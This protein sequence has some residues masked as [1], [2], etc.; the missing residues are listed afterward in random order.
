MPRAPRR[1][2]GDFPAVARRVAPAAH[3]SRSTQPA[4]SLE[5]ARDELVRALLDLVAGCR[6]PVL[7]GTNELAMICAGPYT[8]VER[9][10]KAE[11]LLDR[12]AIG[13]PRAV[14]AA[15]NA[16]LDRLAGIVVQHTR[17]PDVRLRGRAE[18]RQELTTRHGTA[19]LR[20]L[21]TAEY[22]AEYAQERRGSAALRGMA[23]GALTGA[24]FQAVTAKVLIK[25]VDW[26]AQALAGAVS[27]GAMAAEAEQL[28]AIEDVDR[29]RAGLK[30]FYEPLHRELLP[31]ARS[32]WELIDANGSSRAALLRRV[33]SALDD[34]DGREGGWIMRELI[35]CF[36][37]AGVTVQP[38]GS[39]SDFF[40]SASAG[41]VRVALILNQIVLLIATFVGYFWL[42]NVDLAGKA[43]VSLGLF[44][45]PAFTWF[46][47]LMHWHAWAERWNDSVAHR[48]EALEMLTSLCAEASELRGGVS[49]KGTLPAVRALTPAPAG[50]GLMFSLAFWGVVPSIALVLV[51]LVD[52]TLG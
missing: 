34:D 15:L 49:I 8:D 42:P 36:E 43:L 41:R 51:M 37:T 31:L 44:F 40:R 38:A 39:F 46:G 14:R 27:G 17:D 21:R 45:L 4:A 6:A 47:S 18:I 2:S 16:G 48:S 26:K 10:D 12:L 50:Q 52:G 22:G 28:T 33:T 35:S 5:V 19:L 9:A 29:A 13:A 7:K 20:L 3:R 24:A 25:D 11:A 1:S 32:C 30:D 23:T